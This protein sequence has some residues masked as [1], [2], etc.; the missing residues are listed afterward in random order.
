MMSGSRRDALYRELEGG[1][2]LRGAAPGALAPR[3]GGSRSGG[4]YPGAVPFDIQARLRHALEELKEAVVSQ[5]LHLVTTL[6]IVPTESYMVR[7]VIRDSVESLYE[8]ER[9]CCSKGAGKH[10]RDAA[11]Q[12]RSWW[13]KDP[14]EPASSVGASCP[15]LTGFGLVE[16]AGFFQRRPREVAWWSRVFLDMERYHRSDPDRHESRLDRLKTLRMGI[17]KHVLNSLDD[18]HIW[19]EAGLLGEMNKPGWGLDAT[20][21]RLSRELEGR[22]SPDLHPGIP[23]HGFLYVLVRAHQFCLSE[24][25]EGDD[26]ARLEKVNATREFDS[27]LDLMRVIVQRTLKRGV[28]PD[29]VFLLDELQRE[30]FNI[31]HETFRDPYTLHCVPVADTERLEKCRLPLFLDPGDLSGDYHRDLRSTRETLLKIHRRIVGEAVEDLETFASACVQPLP[32][33]RLL[34]RLVGVAVG[35]FLAEVPWPLRV[36]PDSVNEKVRALLP[37]EVLRALVRPRKGYELSS[38]QELKRTIEAEEKRQR[39]ALE[40]IQVSGRVHGLHDY[41]VFVRRLLFRMLRRECGLQLSA[42]SIEEV[43]ESAP[44]D[45]AGTLEWV[46]AEAGAHA[47]DALGGWARTLDAVEHHLSRGVLAGL[48]ETGEEGPPGESRTGFLDAMAPVFH[49]VIVALAR[50]QSNLPR[51]EISESWQRE[52]DLLVKLLA[53]TLAQ[54]ETAAAKVARKAFDEA[55]GPLYRA[56]TRPFLVNAGEWRAAMAWEAHC[57]MGNDPAGFLENADLEEFLE[58]LNEASESMDRSPGPLAL[59]T[60]R[61]AIL[62]LMEKED[63]AGELDR[64]AL[65]ELVRALPQL[66]CGACGESNCGN[67]AGAILRGRA[68]PSGCVQLSP[69]GLTRLLEQLGGRLGR[70]PGAKVSTSPLEALRD[71]AK[72]RGMPDRDSFRTVLSPICRKARSLFLE[73]LKDIWENLSPKPHIFKRPDPE[74]FYGELCRYLGYESAERLT[75]EEKL[76]LIERG[77]VREAAAWDLF[78]QRQ[79]WLALAVR[80]RRGKPLLRAQDPEWVAAHGYGNVFFLQQLSPRDR[81][82]VL[83]DRLERHQDGFSRWWNED[84]L[85]LNHPDF[86]IRDWEDFTK[87]IKNAYWHREYTPSPMD[88]LRSIGPAGLK[89]VGNR[90]AQVRGELLRRYLDHVA[91]REERESD[92]RL[93]RRDEIAR[94]GAVS[95]MS[96]LRAVLEAF[97][98]EHAQAGSTCPDPRVPL[99]DRAAVDVEAV[100][101][102]FQAEGVAFSPGFACRWEELTGRER[103]ALSGEWTPMDGSAGQGGEGGLFLD[104]WGGSLA[105]RAALIRALLMA[106]L[107]VRSRE[108]MEAAWVGAH[109]VGGSAERPPL[110]SLR[111]LV[112]GFV[113]NGCGRPRL[114]EELEPLV[115]ALEERREVIEAVEEDVLH[116]VIRQRACRVLLDGKHR[117]PGQAG[118]LGCDF[119]LEIPGLGDA[120]DTF[121]QAQ[122]PMDRE[123]L[124]HYLFLLAKM[125][126]NLDTLTAL[127]REIRETS[128]IMEA[129]WLRF[130][131]ERILEGPPPRTAPGTALGTRLLFSHLQ[132]KGPVNACL[133]RGVGRREKRNVASAANELLEFLRYHIL[134]RAGEDGANGAA[135]AV[136]DMLEAGYDL[137][138]IDEAALTTAANREWGRLEQLKKRKIWIFTS[139]TARKLAAQHPE[140]NDIERGFQKMRMEI[141]RDARQADPGQVETIGRRGVALGQIKGEMY[142]QLSSLLET[143]R[144]ATFQARIRRIVDELD[145]KREEIVSG[146]AS[147]S[148]NRRTVFYVLRQYQKSV[149]EPLWEDFLRFIVEHWLKPAAEIRS[150]TR[151]DRDERLKELDKRIGAVFGFSPLDLEAETARAAEQDFQSWVND[152][153]EV[154]ADS[155]GGPSTVS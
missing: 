143:E 56:R 15:L 30:G 11:H 127:L 2:P 33:A 82:I 109:I 26:R 98:D 126:G 68:E 48:T 150:S 115:M 3:V 107:Q 80:N 18:L 155:G 61:G 132:D 124:L 119:P 106:M 118:G 49:R 45:E 113:R 8:S 59:E 120:V 7:Q 4:E 57:R 14:W 31:K 16:Q 39:E 84:L 111:L 62:S 88:A 12:V 81:N 141:L 53:P 89:E 54:V 116:Q 69:Q 110:S 66:D 47:I 133:T 44:L 73:R 40:R 142:R 71:L 43:L 37:E 140:L 121:F 21:R 22:V 108:E 130:T 105:K 27:L 79:D 102:R 147:G 131:E 103:E 152:Q 42:P 101:D 36:A 10:C 90:A 29:A 112:R 129:A 67:F 139:V 99:G 60:P 104:G 38:G 151:L 50:H 96:G 17:D 35:W 41:A 97:V 154:L 5:V 117:R 65:D 100:W 153:L 145:E 76:L 128:D 19:L 148:I 136:R 6:F 28:P 58:E 52:I 123:R 138:G 78:R 86:S 51:L 13:G 72:W 64:E 125:E 122:P 146:W 77:D 25:I 32:R 85:T 1:F 24:T 95:D 114:Q 9:R 63:G 134:L 34:H 20:V 46:L 137:T 87:I 149:P 92:R 74:A 83:Q 23:F 91:D 55:R 70:A 94:S 135:R 144:I 75:H 93:A